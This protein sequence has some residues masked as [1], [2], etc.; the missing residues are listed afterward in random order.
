MEP[1]CTSPNSI[2][3]TPPPHERE[4][5]MMPLN[6]T[7]SGASPELGLADIESATVLEAGG[8]DVVPVTLIVADV[9]CAPDTSV[10]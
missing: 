10:I 2:V 1:V 5:L 7:I 6:E 9:R 3:Y 8:G 4:P